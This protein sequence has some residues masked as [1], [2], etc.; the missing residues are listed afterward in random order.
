MIKILGNALTSLHPH[1][2]FPI[3]LP[4]QLDRRL[5]TFARISSDSADTSA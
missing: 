1:A 5:R 3:A 4:I 2:T